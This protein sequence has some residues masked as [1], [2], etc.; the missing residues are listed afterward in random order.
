ML[1]KQQSKIWNYFE[2]NATDESMADCLV[3]QCKDTLKRGGNDPYGTSGLINHLHAKHLDEYKKYTGISDIKKKKKTRRSNAAWKET[4]STD[5]RANNP[6]QLIIAKKIIEMI[7]ANVMP[8]SMINVGFTRLLNE[9]EPH[10]F[11][12]SKV[13]LSRTLIPDLYSAVK[14]SIVISLQQAAYI[15]FTSDVWKSTNNLNAFLSLNAHWIDSK[16]NRMISIVLSLQNLED[17]HTGQCILDNILAD[18]K[19]GLSG[20]DHLGCFI[21][22]IQL[23]VKVELLSQRSIMDAIVTARAIIGRFRHSTQAM[24]QLLRIQKSLICEDGTLYPT[25]C[26]IQD[27]TTRWNSMFKHAQKKAIA[28]YSRE[29]DGVTNLTA[30]EFD[31]T[32]F[33]YASIIQ[34]GNQECQYIYCNSKHDHLQ[35]SR[36]HGNFNKTCKCQR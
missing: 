22:T 12:P 9:L 31:E 15:S 14:S 35:C 36:S 20:L 2:I 26:L 3:P 19:R 1:Q 4:Q 17:R 18:E 30:H 27:V 16:W 21:H 10:Y 28:L 25:H 8:F 6:R 24:E 33:D 5:N 11:I 23:V 34:T 7:A 32:D 29:N 13:H